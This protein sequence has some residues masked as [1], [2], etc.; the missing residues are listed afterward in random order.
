MAWQITTFDD[1]ERKRGQTAASS[2]LHQAGCQSVLDK[3]SG[4]RPSYLVDARGRSDD[5]SQ[6]MSTH[7]I[8]DTLRARIS[9]ATLV[10]ET[11]D[12]VSTGDGLRG[13]C[14]A[15]LDRALGLFVHDAKG[16]TNA[17]PVVDREMWCSGPGKLPGAA[18]RQQ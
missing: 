7:L 14:P 16:Y 2:T 18:K 13:E 5:H 17:S 12:L 15:H 4:A 8:A 6:M 10:G 1:I 9:I 11:V 3:G